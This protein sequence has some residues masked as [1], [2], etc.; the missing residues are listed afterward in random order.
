MTL[1]II[2]L[3]ALVSI[4]AIQR[5]DVMARLQFNAYLMK[6][7]NEWYR[8]VTHALVHAGWLH[9][10]VNMW[11]LWNFGRVAEEFFGAYR[12][13]WGNVL[14]VALYVGGILFSSLPA[15]RQHQDNFSYNAVGASGA[16]SAVLFSSIYF[17][18]TMGIYVMFIPVAI[19]AFVIGPLYLAYEW[20]QHRNSSDNVAHDAHF[21]GAA[22][23][24]IISVML[25]PEQFTMFVKEIG[26]K[27]GL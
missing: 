5:P 10:L 20:Y 6:H 17:M 16:V 2:V 27:L 11:V 3:T 18:P 23:G 8:G 25:V 26:L 13:H 21:W 7:G 4:I 15:Y 14:Y 9:L 24:F 22:F 1:I 12:G 19:P